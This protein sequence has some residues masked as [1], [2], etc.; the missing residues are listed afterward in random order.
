MK[1]FAFKRQCRFVAGI[2]EKVAQWRNTPRTFLTCSFVNM[3]ELSNIRQR[4]APINYLCIKEELHLLG[5]WFQ[6]QQEK[7]YQSE[8]QQICGRSVATMDPN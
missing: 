8:G 7:V 6:R 5:K 1:Y 2:T 3:Q 4:P